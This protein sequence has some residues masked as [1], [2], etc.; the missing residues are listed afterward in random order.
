MLCFLMD[1]DNSYNWLKVKPTVDDFYAQRHKEIFKIIENQ[2]MLG[3]SYNA[4][5]VVDQLKALG[6]LDM[7]GGEQ[8]FIDMMSTFAA[9]SAVGTFIERLK[10]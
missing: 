5:V 8:Y 4:E 1:D 6:L 10:K 3:K 7:V 2:N 9:P